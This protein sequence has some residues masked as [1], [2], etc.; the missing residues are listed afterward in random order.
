MIRS[1]GWRRGFTLIETAVASGVSA[2]LLL[3]LSSTILVASRAVP[4]ADEPLIIND[5]VD[6]ALAALRTD[7]A[8]AVDI[9]QDD[10][11]LL[12]AVPDRNGDGEPEVILYALSA[13]RMLTRSVNQGPRHDLA[14]PLNDI[15]YVL[16]T[17]ENQVIVCR[18]TLE[19]TNAVPP[20]RTITVRL[21]NT[22]RAR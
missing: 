14:G 20:Q 10:E 6:R 9:Y 2:I 21:L 17:S 18:A 7:I 13:S 16:V 22:P 3:S 12:L 19:F 11:E 15:D 1:R 4:S 8:D 5:R